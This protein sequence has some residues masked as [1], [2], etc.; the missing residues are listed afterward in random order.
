V[1]DVTSR[2]LYSN[3]GGNLGM[4]LSPSAP[5]RTVIETQKP[6]LFF[7]AETKSKKPPDFPGYQKFAVDPVPGARGLGLSGGLLAFYETKS[8]YSISLYKDNPRF[9]GVRISDFFCDKPLTAFGAYGPDDHYPLH[10]RETFFEELSEAIIPAAAEGYVIILADLN[11]RLGDIT[12]P[13]NSNK[14]LLLDFIN[15]H[16]LKNL[17]ATQTHGKFTFVSNTGRSIVDYALTT[18]PINNVKLKIHP[19][20]L[21]SNSQGAHRPLILTLNWSA[22]RAHVQT[23]I[24]RWK[25]TN[26]KNIEP[27]TEKL[28]AECNKI[29]NNSIETLTEKINTAKKET[30]GRSKR[31]KPRAPHPRAKKLNS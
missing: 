3:V 12:G 28:I 14:K 22:P 27:Y 18:L 17:N 8:R 13:T 15:N 25:E 30:L 29:Q 24:P 19:S 1:T 4:Q 11:A 31:G 7:L 16:N 26:E 10:A 21:S 20:S 6:L 23:F 9:I 5:L 2:L